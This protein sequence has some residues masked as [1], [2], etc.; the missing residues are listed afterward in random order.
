MSGDNP[1]GP[2]PR[3]AQEFDQAL[4]FGT[5]RRLPRTSVTVHGEP[6]LPRIGRR[7]PA[8]AV[9][10]AAGKGSR[11]GEGAK[12]LCEIGGRPLIEHQLHA[13]AS[14]GITS[15]GMVVGFEQERIREIV[16][17][18]AT[19][20]VNERF[21]ETNSLYSF[22]LARSWVRGDLVVLNS[23][24]LFHPDMIRMLRGRHKNGL[25]FDSRSGADPEEMKVAVRGNR[26]DM[27]SK[28]LPPHRTRGENV[29][30]LSLDRHT[31]RY[32]FGVATRLVARG[33]DRDWLASAINRTARRH[34]FRCV[35]VAGLPWTEI[36]FPEDLDRARRNVWPAIMARRVSRRGA[37]A[38]PV[39]TI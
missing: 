30:I 37:A 35:D 38:L 22:M 8:E 36:D 18:R 28:A 16:G 17:E 14:I 4:G 15:I 6:R 21:A 12:C 27:M 2:A 7:P 29:G 23:D 26:L 3:L 20:I 11:L 19:F 10:L 34:P 1:L 9:I 13:L 33:G 31:A 25:L 32:A 24:V 5:G 39:A